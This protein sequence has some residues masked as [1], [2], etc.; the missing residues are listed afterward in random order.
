[1]VAGI[2]GVCI[3]SFRGLMQVPAIVAGTYCNHTHNGQQVRA[4]TR[5]RANGRH[6]GSHRGPGC[7][8]AIMSML[9]FSTRT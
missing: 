9:V 4:S 6:T 2:G 3:L 1:M 5:A 8:H 7:Q